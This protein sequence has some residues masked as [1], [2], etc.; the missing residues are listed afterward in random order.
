M[1]GQAVSGQEGRVRGTG[2]KEPGKH[3]F[4]K[5]T[6]GLTLEQRGLTC[7]MHGIPVS[8]ENTR[9]VLT[10]QHLCGWPAS[11]LIQMPGTRV[12]A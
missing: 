12:K 6:R 2:N 10:R 7:Q 4:Q 8:C 5:H 11:H 9:T 1:G 3:T